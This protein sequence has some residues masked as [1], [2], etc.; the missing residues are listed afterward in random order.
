MRMLF[1]GFEKRAISNAT[2]G[3]GIGMGAGYTSAKREAEVSNMKE[4]ALPDARSLTE[5]TKSLLPGDVLYSGERV[6]SKSDMKALGYQIIPR[7]G[8]SP[9]FHAMIY[10]GKGKVFDAS[11]DRKD[12]TA[13]EINIKDKYKGLKRED[14][15]VVAYRPIDTSPEQR[16]T[17]V[18]Q[19]RSLMGAKYP[20]NAG[21]FLKGLKT[22]IGIPGRKDDIKGSADDIVCQDV[23]IKAYPDKFEKRHLT[24]AEMQYNKNFTPVAKTGRFDYNKKERS[25]ANTT[26]PI[27]KGL[28]GGIQG[29]IAG[30]VLDLARK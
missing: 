5:F 11:R 17:A 29:L 20:D 30:G 7:L 13:K 14:Y 16:Q 19:A 10:A 27:L 6:K 3:A 2:L 8:G 12:E 28:R 22:L 15:S 21:L 23:A 25:I 1:K 26:Y 24:V 18:R 9:K 4:D